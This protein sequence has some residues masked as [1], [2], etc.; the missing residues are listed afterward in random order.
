MVLLSLLMC[1]QGT[2][3]FYDDGQTTSRSAVGDSCMRSQEACPLVGATP[4]RSERNDEASLA[5]P[6]PSES[7]A[8]LTPAW[9]SRSLLQ[10]RHV[11]SNEV[12]ASANAHD[13]HRVR[14]PVGTDSDVSGAAQLDLGGVGGESSITH[15]SGT[16]M[17]GEAT[18]ESTALSRSSET[19]TAS[20][21]IVGARAE[22]TRRNMA[23]SGSVGI[24]IAAGSVGGISN[25]FV[26]SSG[27]QERIGAVE[28][29]GLLQASLLKFGSSFMSETD[30]TLAFVVVV[31]VLICGVA[32]VC[33][34]VQES[35]MNELGVPHPGGGGVQRPSGL[36]QAP[37][38]C[39]PPDHGLV[40]ARPSV[41]RADSTIAGGVAAR[42][43][44]SP[45]ASFPVQTGPLP[46]ASTD[47]DSRAPSPRNSARPLSSPSLRHPSGCGNPPPR[48]DGVASPSGSAP[49]LSSRA[50]GAS[51]P[52]YPWHVCPGLIVPKSNECVLALPAH[53]SRKDSNLM[54]LDICEISGVPM[55]R[56][57]V[58]SPVEAGRSSTSRSGRGPNSGGMPTVTLWSANGQKCLVAYCWAFVEA[59][60]RKSAYVYDAGEEVFGHITK[61]GTFR[62][63]TAS[64]RYV[65]SSCRQGPQI[66]LQGNFMERAVNITNDRGKILADTEPCS[67]NFDPLGEYYRLRVIELVDVGLIICSLLSVLQMEG[68]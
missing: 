67:M 54:G 5:Q 9:R 39:R 10:T 24:G 47:W 25:G 48:P 15:S 28:V 1:F 56:A 29:L 7:G 59:D 64:P 51:S 3:E 31:C 66:L 53:A 49:Q 58:Q 68:L 46:Q 14:L 36:K 2:S 32:V 23:A 21:D 16:R 57:T 13:A 60:G 40:S 35:Y 45:R 19:A 33:S 22:E 4:E 18:F 43:V 38:Q 65:V 50:P 44:G 41:S 63:P 8:L 34:V 37:F 6:W 52:R 27:A 55:L 30:R 12:S 42:A 62:T 17:G 20:N 26:A 61:V 11:A